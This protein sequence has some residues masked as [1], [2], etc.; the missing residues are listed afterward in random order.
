MRALF[1]CANT[2]GAFTPE[3]NRVF[4]EEKGG[5]FP[6]DGVRENVDIVGVEI[7]ICLI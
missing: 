5:Y 6:M 7:K 2:K 4:P 3:L 1:C